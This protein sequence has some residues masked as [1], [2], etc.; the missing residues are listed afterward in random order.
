MALG[1]KYLHG[2]GVRKSCPNALYH[3][4]FV[5]EKVATAAK[6]LTHSPY[7]SQVYKLT[8]KYNSDIYAR[9]RTLNCGFSP[10][11]LMKMILKMISRLKFF[12][13]TN[14]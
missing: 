2:L 3:Y 7:V 6:T 8:Y 5:A 1:N 14:F 9:K 11:F 12:S 13:M 4:Q 10:V